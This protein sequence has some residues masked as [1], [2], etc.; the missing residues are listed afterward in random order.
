MYCHQC[1]AKCTSEQ[2]LC[3]KCGA[4]LL[5]TDL[6][7]AVI[8]LA[9]GS[10]LSKS[11][12]NT[13]PKNQ[14]TEPH[15]E[16]I[17]VFHWLIP[18]LLAGVVSLGLLIFYQYEQS[19]NQE[20]L[21]LQLQAKEEALDG[22]YSNAVN[23]LEQ[24]EQK[25]PNFAALTR[26][27]ELA[28][29]AAQLQTKLDNASAQLK[30]LKLNE[31]EKLLK[32]VQATIG[33]RK[34]PLFEHLQKELAADQDKLA[35]LRVKG[36]LDKLTT[37]DELSDKL[38]KINGLSGKE[39][40]AVKV[41]IINKIVGLSYTSAEEKQRKKDFIG[42]LNVIDNGLSYDSDNEK[43]TV[44]RKQIVEAK[45]EFEEAE[46]ERIQLAQQKAE[47]E[48]LNNRTAAVEVTELKAMLDD[49]GD[50]SISGIVTN[51]ATR[52]IYSISIDLAIYSTSSGAYIGN[53]YADVSPFRLEPGESGQ[54]STSN[55]GV[56][57]QAEISITNVS[58]YLE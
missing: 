12:A 24:A 27:L 53:A 21:G 43:L 4:R 41:Q 16:K 33:K 45:R 42:A 48:E 35:V 13:D 1:G 47:E 30:T 50:L 40:N 55:Y 2:K 39:A 20:T 26:D 46:E 22:N 57:E 5:T 6:Q 3:K 7:K 34:E 17:S 31:G 38:D 15:K 19:I 36:E 8:E 14:K 51:T 10:G 18:L 49:Y 28:T 23:L 32:Q 56:Y 58:W 54:F 9:A 52:P 29:K 25:R 37:V 11:E 44:Y